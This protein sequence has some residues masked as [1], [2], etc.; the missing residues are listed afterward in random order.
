MDDSCYN[1]EIRLLQVGGSRDLHEWWSYPALASPYWR[2]YWNES[3]GAFVKHGGSK[4]SLGP[5]KIA[6]IAPETQFATSC[7]G[8]SRQLYIHFIAGSPFSNVAPQIFEFMVKEEAFRRE[9][10]EL[11]DIAP[12]R[13]QP[14]ESAISQR[15]ISLM[16]IRIV[17]WALGMLPAGIMP[18][19]RLDPRVAAA[20]RLLAEGGER[21]SNAKLARAAGMAENAFIRL[22]S[23]ESG[24]SPQRYWRLRRIEDACMLLHYSQLDIKEIAEQ[25]G[26]C[27][28]NHF[29][30]AFKAM[31]GLGPAEFRRKRQLGA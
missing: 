3:P 5:E 11:L 27:D 20:M 12:F 1:P 30:R 7:P 15:R 8:H 10:A 18:E 6:L 14:G 16:A 4:R 25:T 21:P 24:Y 26:F 29:S 19:R 23:K 31:R 17:A 13:I 28:R 9:C 2:L 22:F